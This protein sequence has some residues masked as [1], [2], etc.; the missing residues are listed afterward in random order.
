MEIKEIQELPYNPKAKDIKELTRQKGAFS[1]EEILL[2]LTYQKYAQ[3]K[4]T[5]ELMQQLAQAEPETKEKLKRLIMIV[6][7]S[8]LSDEEIEASLKNKK[9]RE[10]ILKYLELI[11]KFKKQIIH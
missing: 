5:L 9:D 11:R 1:D 6:A 10:E 2:E 7:L 3:G 8:D 4:E